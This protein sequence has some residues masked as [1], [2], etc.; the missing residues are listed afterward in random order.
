MAEKDEPEI[1]EEELGETKRKLPLKLI[2]IIAAGLLVLGGGGFFG[3]K[4]FFGK[5]ASVEE[6]GEAKK[7]EEKKGE[8]KKGEEKKGEAKKGEEKKGEATIIFPLDPFI[9]NLADPTG[10]RYL[11]VRVSLE[12]TGPDQQQEIER[13]LPQV[14]DGILLLLSSKTFADISSMEGK[15]TLRTEILH[16]I[17]QALSKSKVVTIYFTEFVVQ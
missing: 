5:K 10:N 9:V 2:I 6:A 4:F 13:R 12:L 17:N 3:Y 15:L 16:R 11:K 8:V 1:G 7:G 14:R